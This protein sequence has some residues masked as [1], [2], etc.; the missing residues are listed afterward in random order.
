MKM[1]ESSTIHLFRGA[2]IVRSWSKYQETI[3]DWALC[4]A[5]RR[6][7]DDYEVKATE[8][9]EEVNC[10]FCKDLMRA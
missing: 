6:R 1:P 3:T 7:G 10:R 9:P 8:N 5:N 2:P 4:G